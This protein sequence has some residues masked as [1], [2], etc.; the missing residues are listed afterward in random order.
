MK[1]IVLV[2]G[3]V[4][5]AVVAGCGSSSD[6]PTA[7]TS[8]ALFDGRIATAAECNQGD[9]LY[10][11]WHGVNG[12]PNDLWRCVGRRISFAASCPFGC[13]HMPDGENDECEHQRDAPARPACASG[14]GYY[15]GGGDIGGSENDLYVCSGGV[16]LYVRP[17]AT[18]CVREAPGV[19]D[20]CG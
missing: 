6:E 3:G 5:I 14:D 11:G 8:D 2:C 12:S 4:L 20:H 18:G 15:C 9:G 17:C 16:P 13:L 1:T 10:C 7:S 19:D